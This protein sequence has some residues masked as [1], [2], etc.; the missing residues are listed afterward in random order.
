MMIM[1]AEE[2]EE[3][4]AAQRAESMEQE[5]CCF[6]FVSRQEGSAAPDL[7]FPCAALTVGNE[8]TL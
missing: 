6:L 1:R 7:A 2:R 4:L 8:V 5:K 3:R